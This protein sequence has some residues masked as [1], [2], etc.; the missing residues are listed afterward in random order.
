MTPPVK[1]LNQ[2]REA[3]TKNQDA[4]ALLEANLFA[5]N[6]AFE[7]ARIGRAGAEFADLVSE[8][9]RVSEGQS[10]RSKK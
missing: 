3:N 4:F 10:A 5:V 9:E 2:A 8:A 7:A 6:A 1:N